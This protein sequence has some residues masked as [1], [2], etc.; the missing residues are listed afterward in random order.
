MSHLCM[1][2]TIVATNIKNKGVIIF[3]IVNW[4]VLISSE[5]NNQLRQIRQTDR[6]YQNCT[7]VLQ[8]FNEGKQVGQVF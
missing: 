3:G 5:K 7:H 8:V 4:K 2:F 6:S 1:L